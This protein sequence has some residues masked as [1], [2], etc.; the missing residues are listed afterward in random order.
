[1]LAG[2]WLAG[3]GIGREAWR[4][5]EGRGPKGQGREGMCVRAACSNERGGLSGGARERRGG[6]RRPLARDQAV[7]RGLLPPVPSQ[8]IHHSPLTPS[9]S[10]QSP[11]P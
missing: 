6:E 3:V 4:K 1:M 11:T 2:L 8:H 10:S 7:L 9:E 5:A